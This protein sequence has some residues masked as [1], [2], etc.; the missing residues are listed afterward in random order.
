[1]QLLA[2]DPSRSL[3]ALDLTWSF[4]GNAGGQALANAIKSSTC[5]LNQLRLAGCSMECRGVE[6]LADALHT[7][8][9]LT[10]LDLRRNQPTDEGAHALVRAMRHSKVLKHLDLRGCPLSI[11]ALRMCAQESA[12]Q[13]ATIL[14]DG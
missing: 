1:M 12:A 7:N 4:C 3:T 11:F 9:S 2:S 13:H 14:T 8:R 10:L 5:S 6:A